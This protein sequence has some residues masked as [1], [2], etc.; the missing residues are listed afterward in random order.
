VS[1]SFLWQLKYMWNNRRALR[2]PESYVEFLRRFAA[3]PEAAYFLQN[4][5]RASGYPEGPDGGWRYEFKPLPAQEELLKAY[6]LNEIAGQES[7]IEIQR[8][9][10]EGLLIQVAQ[11]ALNGAQDFREEYLNGFVLGSLLEIGTL[12]GKCRLLP[13]DVPPKDDGKARAITV[14]ELLAEPIIKEP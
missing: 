14:A 10:R 5:A 3:A 9:H 4:S 13:E 1:I 11:Y 6:G 8:R 7:A 2:S 12:D